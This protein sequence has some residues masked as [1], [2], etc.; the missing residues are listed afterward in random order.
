MDDFTSE[1]IRGRGLKCLDGV[2]VVEEAPDVVV[3]ASEASLLSGVPL[4]TPH[5][6]R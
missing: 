6:G 4:S 5:D 2:L 3:V 1:H